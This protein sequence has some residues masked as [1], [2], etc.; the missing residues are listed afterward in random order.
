MTGTGGKLLVEQLKAAGCKYVFTTP[1]SGETPIYDALVDD[2]SIQ[3]IQVLQEGSVAAVAD[4]YG[5]ATGT[6]PFVLVPRPGLENVMS[7]MFNAWKDLPP[8]W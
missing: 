5:R 3:L 4:G 2:P 7:Q 8:W 1:S 6:V